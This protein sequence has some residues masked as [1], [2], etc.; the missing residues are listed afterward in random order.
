M[1]FETVYSK[2]HNIGERAICKPTFNTQGPTGQFE[3]YTAA[4]L[5][6][7]WCRWHKGEQVLICYGQVFVNYAFTSEQPENVKEIVHC[8]DLA[9]AARICSAFDGRMGR[10]ALRHTLEASKINRT[11][12]LDGARAAWQAIGEARIARKQHL[13][14]VS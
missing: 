3:E 1:G 11:E 13:G 9:A 6:D 12:I 7:V 10:V 4:V 2:T 8:P 5:L 14:K